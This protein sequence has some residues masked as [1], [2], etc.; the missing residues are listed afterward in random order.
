LP[1]SVSPINDYGNFA[2]SNT[3]RQISG[4]NFLLTNRNT[5][6]L[7]ANDLYIVK[8]NFDLRNQDKIAGT[9]NYPYSSYSNNGD[10][11][12]M[13]N[14]QTIILRVGGSSLSNVASGSTNANIRLTGVF[15][16]PYIQLS[17]S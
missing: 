8:F 12:F 13:R 14:C 2:V 16:N 11:I 10:T 6:P 15:Y 3:F 1:T 7:L 4:I 5:K 17:T 9:F